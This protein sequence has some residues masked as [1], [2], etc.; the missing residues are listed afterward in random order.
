ME[1]HLSTPNLIHHFW[2][3]SMNLIHL[4]QAHTPAQGESAAFGK[5]ASTH[6][7][8]CSSRIVRDAKCPPHKRQ[9]LSASSNVRPV[10]SIL[11][12]LPRYSVQASS[13][14]WIALSTVCSSWRL[15]LTSR[16]RAWVE[17]VAVG[18]RWIATVPGVESCTHRAAPGLAPGKL[19]SFPARCDSHDCRSSV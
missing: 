5:M 17:T 11:Y 13:L 7:R 3:L 2:H 14:H 1:I 9:L 19:S 10:E 15:V 12:R 8:S 18:T 4:W 16:C 6:T